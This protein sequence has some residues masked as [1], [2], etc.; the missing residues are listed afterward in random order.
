MKWEGVVFAK[1]TVVIDNGG[2]AST[3]VSGVERDGSAQDYGINR[4]G[5]KTIPQGIKRW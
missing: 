1:Q 5:P 4:E 2:P 3:G